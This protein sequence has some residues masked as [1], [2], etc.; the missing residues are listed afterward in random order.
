[1]IDPLDNQDTFHPTPDMRCDVCDDN[2]R[3]MIYDWYHGDSIQLCVNC[4][5]HKYGVQTLIKNYGKEF[6]YG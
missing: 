2:K 1:M 6:A 4:Y 5:V 3:H